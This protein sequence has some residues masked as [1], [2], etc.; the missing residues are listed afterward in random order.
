MN[1]LKLGKP[2]ELKLEHCYFCD[3]VCGCK[4]GSKVVLEFKDKNVKA[5][6]CN[7]CQRKIKED[8]DKFIEEFYE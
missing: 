7:I 6:V 8:P 3:C 1:L 4:A 5:F 2:I